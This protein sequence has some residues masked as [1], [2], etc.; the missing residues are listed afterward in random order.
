MLMASQKV[1]SPAL[2]RDREMLGVLHVGL[3]LSRHHRALYI[4]LFAEPSQILIAISSMLMVSQKK[5]HFGDG[6]AKIVQC[7][8]RKLFEMGHTQGTPP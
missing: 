3:K 4:E 2:R 6:S 8:A 5:N 1:R 7:L